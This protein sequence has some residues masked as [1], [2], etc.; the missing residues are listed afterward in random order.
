MDAHGT[1]LPKHQRDA[2]KL[3]EHASSQ[4]TPIIV[5][6]CPSKIVPDEVY[7]ILCAV[8]QHPASDEAEIVPL[9][10]LGME[11]LQVIVAPPKTFGGKLNIIV[12]HGRWL[13]GG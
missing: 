11:P 13:L 9:A 2:I 8:V 3:L 12:K 4:Q 10:M 1:D 7:N 6:E 5:L